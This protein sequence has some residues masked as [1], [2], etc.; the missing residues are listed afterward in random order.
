MGLQLQTLQQLDNW[1]HG[2]VPKMLRSGKFVFDDE[3]KH[4]FEPVDS[5]LR[6]EKLHVLF[7]ELMSDAL[8]R[9]MALGAIRR[10]IKAATL[11]HDR[12]NKT[13]IKKLLA[14]YEV[15]CKRSFERGSKMFLDF[16]FLDFNFLETPLVPAEFGEQVIKV[17]EWLVKANLD[18]FSNI[19]NGK[20]ACL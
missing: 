12:A 18:G 1:A 20:L 3:G 16:N 10:A 17:E 2:E 4:L 9:D 5:S 8:N 6:S 14:D 7:N 19:H 13:Y 15:Q 11:R